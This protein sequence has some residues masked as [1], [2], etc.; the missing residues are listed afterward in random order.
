M[1]PRAINRLVWVG[2]L[3]V[4]AT[5]AWR[6]SGKYLDGRGNLEVITDGAPETLM[7]SWSGE[8][9]H[10]M[11]DSIA[12]A[13]RE[14]G[15]DRKRVVLVLDSPG[16]LLSHGNEVIT[17]LR[18][19]GRTHALETVVE[20]RSICASMCVPIYLQGQSRVAAPGARFMFHEVKVVD[21]LTNERQP[22][23]ERQKAANT[24][25]FLDLYF[26]PAGV[27]EAW[28]K[29]VAVKIQGRDYWRTAKQLVDEKS[30]IVQ[31]L[32]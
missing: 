22:Q 25:Q 23:S 27:P 9:R 7:L 14:H 19:I 3:A 21:P 26:R 2:M 1:T 8:V 10:P 17:E 16:G 28:M 12:K 4:I 6:Y 18:R 24:F 15:G 31:H 11:A 5:L 29:D 30:G 32:N 13:F 20:N